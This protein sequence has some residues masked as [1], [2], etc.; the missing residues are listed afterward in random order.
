VTTNRT[1]TTERPQVRDGQVKANWD[2]PTA[3]NRIGCSPYTLRA[4]LRERRLPFIKAGR[5]VLL[6]PE[7][8]EKFIDANRVPVLVR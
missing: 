5:R 6:D 3:A 4:W 7:D 8:V 2:V 1:K